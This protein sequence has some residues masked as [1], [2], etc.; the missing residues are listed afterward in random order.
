MR[1]SHSAAFT[2]G[3]MGGNPAGVSIAGTFPTEAVM[4]EQAA[5]LG[6]SETAFLAPADAADRFHIRYFSPEMEV[7]FCGHA[8][9]AG[10]AVL[11]EEYGPGA[12]TLLLSDGSPVAVEGK[13]SPQG[14][15]SAAFLSPPTRYAAADTLFVDKILHH[16][17]LTQGALI[18]GY[19]PVI[20]EAGG[21]D[22]ILSLK[23]RDDLIGMSY[24]FE[25]V[26]KLT[27]EA[28]C[29]TVVLNWRESDILVNTRVA[30]AYGGVI[31]DPATGSAAASFAGYLRDTGQLPNPEF[32]IIQ[33]HDMG[34][35]C[36]IRVRAE[37]GQGDPVRISG[38]VVSL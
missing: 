22:L 27:L 9:I 18:D 3:T 31:E 11:A 5:V 14:E 1:F 38:T 15:R 37:G 6:Y 21:R 34:Q 36:I 7:P 16:F 13:I 4:Q 28:D 32:R 2:D 17:S 20:A 10:A 29:I 12:Y 33:G 24:D 19:T 8:T 26:R 30:F 35:R 23:S 25:A